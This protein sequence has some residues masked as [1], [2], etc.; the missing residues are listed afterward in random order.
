MKG[1]RTT[2]SVTTQSVDK[3]SWNLKR[4]I[5]NTCWQR[6]LLSLRR[7][8]IEVVHGTVTLRGTVNSFYERQ[9]CLA[10]TQHVPGVYKLIDDI[11]VEWASKSSELAAVT[12]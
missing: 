12:T 6:G 7:I 4:R 8:D 10:C 9:L 1:T 2:L 11:K 3:H 5:T